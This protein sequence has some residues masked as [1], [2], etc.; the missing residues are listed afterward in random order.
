ML[1]IPPLRERTH[2]IEHYVNIFKERFTEKYTRYLRISDE[3]MQ[4]M[5]D[6]SWPG[7]ITQLE[8]FCTRLFLTTPKK[9]IRE[10]YVRCLLDELYPHI[11]NKNGKEKEIIY[12][13]P[14]AVRIEELLNKHHGNRAAV[15]KE[16]GIST[17]TLW[18]HIKKYE[19][20]KNN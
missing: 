10:D 15:A 13:S 3:A 20:N 17:T 4:V 14:E 9:T 11:E 6:Y 18:R 2:D 5:K 8:G 19:V 1:R 7:N 12:K 16:M